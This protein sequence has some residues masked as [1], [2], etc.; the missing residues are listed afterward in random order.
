MEI[1]LW[2]QIQVK[3]E[4]LVGQIADLRRRFYRFLASVHRDPCYRE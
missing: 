2:S 3:D 4:V 1:N